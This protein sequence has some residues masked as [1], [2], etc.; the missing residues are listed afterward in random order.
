MQ[1]GSFVEDPR[2]FL[3]PWTEAKPLAATLRA[4]AVVSFTSPRT[5][6]LIL[7]RTAISGSC[8]AEFFERIE[9]TLRRVSVPEWRLA[10]CFFRGTV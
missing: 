5:A 1:A 7:L 4:P 2:A 9:N 6:R 3:A 10:E 8:V